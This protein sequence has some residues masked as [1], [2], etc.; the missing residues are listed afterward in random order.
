M[1][2]LVLLVRWAKTLLPSRVLM[3]RISSQK[4]PHFPPKNITFFFCVWHLVHVFR[5]GTDTFSHGFCGKS[6][7]SI[8]NSYPTPHVPVQPSL[9]AAVGLRGSVLTWHAASSPRTQSASFCQPHGLGSMSNR[10]N[11]L[12]RQELTVCQAILQMELSPQMSFASIRCRKHKQ[13]ERSHNQ[14]GLWKLS[15][16]FHQFRLQNLDEFFDTNKESLHPL[17]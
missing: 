9:H 13:S 5:E 17:M 6:V 7:Q 4:P 15:R 12:V 3:G 11:I 16:V 2:R 1:H 14:I 8:Q 10:S